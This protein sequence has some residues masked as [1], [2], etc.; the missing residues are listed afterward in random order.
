MLNGPDAL[1]HFPMSMDHRSL[2]RNT[3]AVK[4]T[5][6][7]YSSAENHFDRGA[8]ATDRFANDAVDDDDS[9]G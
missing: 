9:A 2:R 7:L 8:T 5:I 6:K 1:A 3:G 4:A